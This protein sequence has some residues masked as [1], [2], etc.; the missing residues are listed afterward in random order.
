MKLKNKIEL[1]Q[2][3]YWFVV[4]SLFIIIGSM[5]FL[6]SD[7]IKNIEI[8]IIQFIFLMISWG[9]LLIN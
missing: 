6:I 3:I 1:K 7:E 9:L 2:R 8:V 5:K 4:I